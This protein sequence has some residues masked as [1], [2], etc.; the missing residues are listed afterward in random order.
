LFQKAVAPILRRTHTITYRN[1]P[2]KGCKQSM[3]TGIS[4]AFMGGDARQLEVI[5]KF[6]E[7]D[8]SVTLIGFDNLG[9]QFSSVTNAKLDPV[10]LQTVDVLILPAVGTDDS[11]QV[12]SIFSSE[13]MRLTDVHISS[14]PKHAKVI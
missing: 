9:R 11:G 5:Q 13:E 1:G 14:L 3:L 6:T 12:E 8:A 10:L 2:R 4:V 7:L